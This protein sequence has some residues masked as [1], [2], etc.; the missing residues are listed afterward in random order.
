MKLRLFPLGALLALVVLA[1]CGD[2]P[3]VEAGQS[4]PKEITGPVTSID[5]ESLGEVTSFEVTQKGEV[6]VVLIDPEIDYGFALSHLN[7]HL[8]SGDPVRVGLDERNGELY[9][10]GIADA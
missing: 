6:Y 10:T 1:A 7:E 3:A 4:A 8:A 9:A 5:S 2:D